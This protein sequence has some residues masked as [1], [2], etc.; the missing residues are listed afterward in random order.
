MVLF[1]L[2][3]TMMNLVFWKDN[4]NADQWITCCTALPSNIRLDHQS[5][6]FVINAPDHIFSLPCNAQHFIY[7][8]LFALLCI[9]TSMK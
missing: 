6:F 4:T 1:S 5:F 3:I 7:F 8:L 9:H 2:T